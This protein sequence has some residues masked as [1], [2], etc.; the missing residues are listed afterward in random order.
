MGYILYWCEPTQVTTAYTGVASQTLSTPMSLEGICILQNNAIATISS[1]TLCEHCPNVS[2]KSDRYK[3]QL[4]KSSL[5]WQKQVAEQLHWQGWKMSTN[6]WKPQRDI[7]ARFSC[8]LHPSTFSSLPTRSV[9]SSKGRLTPLVELLR[10]HSHSF[11]CNTETSCREKFLGAADSPTSSAICKNE[12]QFM[13]QEPLK[14]MT[15]YKSGNSCS[16]D[17]EIT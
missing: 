9:P 17:G 4:W 2:A 10:E 12:L 7:F 8:S 13:A 3:K 5:I 15:W 1:D 14:Y 11:H 16:M 6:Y